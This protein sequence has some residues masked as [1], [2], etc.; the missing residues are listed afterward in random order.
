MMRTV[1]PKP[2]TRTPRDYARRRKNWQTGHFALLL[3]DCQMPH[4]DGFAL[5][6]AIRAAHTPATVRPIIIPITANG[7]HGEAERCIKGGMDDFITKPM[8]LVELG[9]M[10]EKYKFL[11]L[12]SEQLS[13]C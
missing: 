2:S 13:R 10:L 6:V 7:M 9:A 1:Y 3:T 11:L 12:I 4:I 8:R 5:T